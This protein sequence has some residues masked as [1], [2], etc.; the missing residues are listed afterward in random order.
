MEVIT[1]KKDF[2]ISDDVFKKIIRDLQFELK[3]NKKEIEKLNELDYKYNHRKV[4][5]DDLIKTID[6][7][8]DKVVCKKE[9][10]N[11]VVIYYGDPYATI[12][13]VLSAI[14]NCQNINLIINDVCFGVNKLIVELYKEILKKYRIYDVVSFNNYETKGDIE[15][16][17][18]D[19][20]YIYCLGNKN[21]F[22][23]CS[24]IKDVNIEY[25]PF[26]SIDIYCED[27]EF[28]ELATKILSVCVEFG[29]EAEIFENIDFE[30]AVTY[31]N[32]HG[33]K[34]CSVILTKNNE[35]IDSFKK[36][37]KSK[38]VLANENPFENDDFLK[39]PDI[40]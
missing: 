33:K 30:E 27:D 13:L 18:K 17:K 21:L 26:S 14:L 37:V 25:I 10:K 15:K 32:E 7:Y 9:T 31:L 6:C 29:V 22:N 34:Y 16:N 39:I 38:Y 8:N 1:K 28:Y 2:V 12:Q 36:S 5:V 40:F 3:D 24:K 35:Y 11:I 4:Y 23:N 19:I 20:D